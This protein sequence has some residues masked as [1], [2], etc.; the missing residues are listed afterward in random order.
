M[1]TPNITYTVHNDLCTGCGVCE[2][3]CPSNAISFIVAEGTFRPVVN[4]S[5]CKNDKGCH[6]CYDSCPGI[7]I[8]LKGVLAKNT[9]HKE[10]K[11]V[12]TYLD[13]YVG[14]SLDKEIR[15]HSAS[16]GMITQFLI[17][18]LDKHYIDGA[19]VTKFD[20]KA[21]LNVKS[22]IA[23]SKEEILQAKS[24]KYAPVVL[25][26]AFVELKKAKGTRY[27]IV[28]L[29]CHIQGF[30][31]AE[32][33][34]KRLQNKIIGYFAI[35]C[36]SSRTYKFT[37]YVLKERGINITNVDYLSYRDRGNQGGLVVTGTDA[38]GDAF[39][40]YQDYRKY[41]HPLR[42]IFVPRRCLLC[43]D[44]YGEL[45]DIS[46]GDINVKPYNKDKIGINSIV[47][48]NQYWNRLLNECRNENIVYLENVGIDIVNKSQPSA[49]MKKH[50][51]VGFVSWQKKIGHKV[52]FYGMEFNNGLTLKIVAQYYINRLQQFIGRNESLWFVIKYIK[53]KN[54][55]NRSGNSI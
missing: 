2:G 26:D 28:G 47:V 11:Y 18:L 42:S 9:D 49:K 16:G 48:R 39:D 50:R 46:F 25:N 54:Y 35:Y 52:P 10:D 24:S 38:N 34:D 51:N 40:Y 43:I 27:V 30:R 53:K 33:V 31:K 12:G 19:V 23:T 8:D 17:W 41:C 1:K 13:S 32:A 29:P 44:H 37:D 22:F 4:N 7:G 3:M 55:E 14:Y 15:Y 45:S 6:R 36:S 21:P 20:K 5:L